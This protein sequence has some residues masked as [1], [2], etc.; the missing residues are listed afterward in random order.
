MIRRLP[1]ALTLVAA[2]ALA[3]CSGDPEQPAE[4]MNE[5]ENIVVI[6]ETP[7]ENIVEPEPLSTPTPTPT[8]TPATDAVQTEEQVMDDA[9]AVG[10]TARV[11]RE[12]VGNTVG[13]VN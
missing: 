1:L 4:P 3:A 9:D 2:T 7:S 10:M 8:P 5:A 12:D 13:P 6:D 11:P